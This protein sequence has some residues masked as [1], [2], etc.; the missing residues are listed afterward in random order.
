[1]RGFCAHSFSETVNKSTAVFILL[2][3]YFNMKTYVCHNSK[4][5]SI[6]NDD[7]GLAIEEITSKGN[8]CDITAPF[9]VCIDTD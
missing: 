4:Q 6:V 5:Y 3:N 7:T 1:M 8:V 9:V 2:A